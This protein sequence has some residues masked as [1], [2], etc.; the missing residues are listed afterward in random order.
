MTRRELICCLLA[1]IHSIYSNSFPSTFS[2]T[3]SPPHT[4]CL[5]V[6]STTPC[7][8]S[9]WQ[10]DYHICRQFKHAPFQRDPWNR[11]LEK[12]WISHQIS[13]VFFFF[14]FFTFWTTC[15][16]VFFRLTQ[17]FSS[18][19]AQVLPDLTPFSRFTSN[20]ILLNPFLVCL[21]ALP[22]SIHPKYL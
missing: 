3:I 15:C 10:T 16:S 5:S 7:S 2:L 8:T 11:A 4:L 9:R 14:F 6:C 1:H 21:L 18:L 17:I 13:S 12:A 20:F 22:L 19:L